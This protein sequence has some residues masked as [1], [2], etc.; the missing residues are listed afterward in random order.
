M[1]YTESLWHGITDKDAIAEMKRQSRFGDLMNK[2]YLY[3]IQN[4]ML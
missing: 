4:D 2:I 3:K 1:S